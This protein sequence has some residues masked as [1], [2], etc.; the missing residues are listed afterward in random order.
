MASKPSI[1]TILWLIS[2]AFVLHEAEDWN[3]VSW[4]A[5]NFEPNNVPENFG[6][7]TLGNLTTNGATTQVF[8]ASKPHQITSSGVTSYTHDDSGNVRSTGGRYYKFDSAE[9][10]VCVSSTSSDKCDV[11]SVAYDAAGERVVETSAAVTRYFL[12]PDFVLTS[13]TGNTG[14]QDWRLDIRAFGEPVAYLVATK[15]YF[16]ELL[17]A[18]PLDLPPWLVALVPLAALGFGLGQAIAVAS[19]S[20]SPSAPARPR[21]RA[22]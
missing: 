21:S 4:L 3:L 18:L 12:S 19:S 13:A 16:S 5:A 2:V 6:Y 9:R 7:D 1:R 8:D 22:C 15:P 17:P 20:A 14:A 10:L 11:L